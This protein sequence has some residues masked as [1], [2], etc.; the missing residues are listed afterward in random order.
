MFTLLMQLIGSATLAWDVCVIVRTCPSHRVQLPAL[1]LSLLAATESQP[2]TSV[3]G[4]VVDTENHGRSLA[5]IDRA[6][7][8][9]SMMTSDKS[10]FHAVNHRMPG[11]V[12]NRTLYGYDA[13]QLVLDSMM[14]GGGGGGGSDCTYFLFTNGDNLY[15]RYLFTSLH[16]KMQ[17]R[18][19]LIAFDFVSHHIGNQMHPVAF[20][21]AEIDLGS[22]LV[23]RAVL[24]TTKATFFREPDHY[25]RAYSGDWTLFEKLMTDRNMQRAIVR[26]VLFLHM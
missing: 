21:F 23:T 11:F 7:V 12:G 4:V 16:D 22:A 9:A 1:L 8:L 26:K 14:L 18:V 3:L 13:T 6:I 19:D 17:A 5:Y 25:Y 24:Q 10:V 15:S 20:Q 2:G